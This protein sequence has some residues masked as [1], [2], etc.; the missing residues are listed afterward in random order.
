MQGRGDLSAA[1]WRKSSYNDGQG[2][3]CAE[4]TDD[5]P[6]FVPVRDSR[7]PE[8]LAVVI[9]STGW[10]TFA[11]AASPDR[12]PASDHPGGTPHQPS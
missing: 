4:V 11:T 3:S 12:A 6:G 10:S 5:F 8:G 9:R 2:G 1:V 7:I